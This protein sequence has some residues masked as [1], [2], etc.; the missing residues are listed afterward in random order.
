MYNVADLVVPI[1]KIVGLGSAGFK[2]TGENQPD[3]DSLIKLITSTIEPESWD[4]VG[5]PGSIESFE[6][7]LSLVVSQTQDVH[8]QIADR[9]VQLRRQLNVQVSC[10][11]R[12]ITMNQASYKEI[13]D[14]PPNHRASI[15][16][17]T[18]RFLLLEAFKNR[19]GIEIVRGPKITFFPGQHVT[20]PIDFQLH[21]KSAF[22]QCLH[23]KSIVS[24]NRDS[25]RLD[26]AILA[27]E[28]NFEKEK[29]N[30]TL[31]DGHS[32]LLDVTDQI[33]SNQDGSAASESRPS[34]RRFV[35][36]TPH[37]YVDDEADDSTKR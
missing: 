16:N 29:K 1:P 25:V 11:L 6:T 9:L 30:A 2:P 20:L 7:N 3:F 14:L 4:K 24:A 35:L 13:W 18:E 34:L 17:P 31:K 32:M 10:E 19:D 23:L 21:E 12:T 28:A 27:N 8:D 15:L 5:G 22:K 26:H 37:V 36:I 33:S